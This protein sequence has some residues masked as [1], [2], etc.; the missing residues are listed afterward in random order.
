MKPG[1]STANCV[2]NN[3]LALVFCRHVSNSVEF[4]VGQPNKVPSLVA[5]NDERETRQTGVVQVK[6]KEYIRT[7]LWI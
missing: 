7:E 2:C 4:S 1:G 3:R 6:A 5:L